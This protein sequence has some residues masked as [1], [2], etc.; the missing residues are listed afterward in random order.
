MPVIRAADARRRGSNAGLATPSLGATE[1]VVCSVR[2]EAGQSGVAHKD[3]REEIVVVIEGSGT[4]TLD[5]EEHE[6]AAGDSGRERS[7]DAVAHAL[8]FA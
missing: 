3:D 5:G 4:A 8:V 7:R 6:I 2:A 1:L